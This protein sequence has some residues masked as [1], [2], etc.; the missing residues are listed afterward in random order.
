MKHS[1]YFLKVIPALSILLTTGCKTSLT[2]PS[3]FTV[4][5]GITGTV[6]ASDSHSPIAG[7]TIGLSTS[8]A[9][10]TTTNS[11]GAYRFDNVPVGDY[12]VSFSNSGYGSQDQPVHVDSG[13][14]S[15]LNAALVPIAS[16][17]VVSFHVRDARTGLPVQGIFVKG[18][19]DSLLTDAQG[20]VQFA[21]INYGSPA[22]FSFSAPKYN[23]VM[24]R[25]IAIGKG[26]PVH[27]TISVVRYEDYLVCSYRFADNFLDSSSKGHDAGQH[28][29]KFVADRF[30]NASGAL[31]LNGTTDYVS[32]PDAVDLN[33]GK[34]TDFTI[35][36]WVNYSDPSISATPFY[37]YKG[38]DISNIFTGYEVTLYQDYFQALAG[39]TYGDVQTMDNHTIYGDG[40]WHQITCLF[41][42]SS[43][44]SIYV[45]GKLNRKGSDASSSLPGNINNSAPLLIGGD[46]TSK[47]AYKGV[48]DDVKIYGVALDDGAILEVYHENGW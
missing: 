8:V 45:D 29:G 1:F 38:T 39:T 42:R 12:I 48:I 22:D 37:I 3:T 11:Q 40:R 2:E 30:G 13:A 7:V 21:F 25:G 43:G 19:S 10:Q 18:E 6:S 47:N 34:T 20:N 24:K 15:I 33:F 46:G 16:A 44:I 17:A 26:Y 27:D 31:Q 35:C 5:Q 32:I 28:G 9:N 36:F 23:T 41:T 4:K 14:N